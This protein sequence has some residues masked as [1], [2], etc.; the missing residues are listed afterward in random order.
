ME[1]LFVFFVVL[2]LLAGL[3]AGVVNAADLS[4]GLVGYWPLD[5][6]GEDKAGNSEGT[7]EGDA[8]WIDNGRVNG[9]VML[10][11][12]TGH[13]AISGFE[14]TTTE[15]T[16]IAW[17][18]GGKEGD[19][20][21]IICSRMD[22]MTFWV[23]FTDANTLSYVWNDNAEAT[24]GWKAG[25][26][27]PQDEWAM[28]AITIEPDK[29]VAYIYTDADGLQSA[30]N[31]IQ[32]IEQTIADNLKIGRDECCGDTRHVRGIIDEVMIYDRALSEDDISSLAMG[33]LSVTAPGNGLA[34]TWG[35]IKQ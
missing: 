18:N 14:L 17:L 29:A 24:W 5:G 26:I 13:V 12:I 20:A 25:P 22:P 10:D 33:G 30:V 23:G 2:V 3:T 6:N 9:A 7:L 19:W 21:G 1:R 35:W 8:D 16:A 28:V 31:A 34:A 15:V 4:S 11:G 32:H 27:I